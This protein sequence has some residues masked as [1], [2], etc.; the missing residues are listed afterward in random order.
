MKRGKEV[1][2]ARPT[3]LCLILASIVLAGCF[4]LEPEVV[5]S[6]GQPQALTMPTTPPRTFSPSK[7]LLPK[8]PPTSPEH[9]R[10]GQW[11]D[12]GLHYQ[13]SRETIEVP[14]MPF[15]VFR[16]RTFGPA[17]SASEV[18]PQLP[19]APGGR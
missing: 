13:E 10:M 17:P 6:Q 12:D 2:V 15:P 16:R 3:A 4:S 19:P 11:S 1:D 14:F 8:L 18:N 7:P 9:P 5:K